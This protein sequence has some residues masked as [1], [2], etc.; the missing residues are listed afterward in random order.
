MDGR[1][2]DKAKNT[3]RTGTWPS[4][5]ASPSLVRAMA[6]TAAPPN[7]P[8]GLPPAVYNPPLTSTGLH[9]MFDLASIDWAA[10]VKII[11]ID[12]MLGVDNAIVIALAC[13]SLPVALRKKAVLLGTAG[14]VLLRAVLLAFA[15]LLMGLTWVKLIAGAYLL[16]IGFNLLM[17]NGDDHEVASAEHI[18]GA[19]KTII[20]ADFMMSLDNVLAVVAASQ[21]TGAHSTAYAISGIVLSIPVIIFGAQ[22]I[23]KL[24]D[25]FPIIIWLG[26]G[27]LGWV[28]AEMM[29]TDPVL[30]G[31]I[32]RV[33]GSL[34][35]WT[36]I[37]YKVAGFAA[38][39]FAVLAAKRMRGNKGA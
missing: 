39:I 4:V 2:A 6:N 21:S 11:G 30:E 33:H 3:P 25:R 12:I 34:H 22:G 8:T 36:H 28:G 9:D 31:Y 10:I 19:V 17:E 29:I 5:G 15:G 27:L 23:M 35:D 24:M 38:V 18:L 16:Y 26:A 14:A 37:T 1:A 20:I 13:A 32:T 7:P